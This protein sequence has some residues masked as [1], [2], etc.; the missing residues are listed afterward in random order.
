MGSVQ[1]LFIYPTK[2]CAAV[3]LESSK[4]TEEG[5]LGDRRIMLTGP[6]GTFL[7][8][9]S[10]PLLAHI[11]LTYQ[12]QQLILNFKGHTERFHHH[13][14]SPCTVKI[15]QDTASATYLGD[16]ISHHLSQILETEV[17]VVKV[18]QNTQRWVDSRYCQ[19]KVSYGFAEI[20]RAHV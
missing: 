13:S 9:R 8:Q 4:L 7:S 1:S 5:L 11:S 19:D 14:N 20:G 15:W 3:P 16:D 12:D 6:D 17:H 18:S 2:S 10:H